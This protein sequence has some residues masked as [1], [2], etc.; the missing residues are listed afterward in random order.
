MPIKIIIITT[1]TIIIHTVNIVY[2][3]P[4]NNL[5]LMKGVSIVTAEKK[6]CHGLNVETDESFP[7]KSKN[8]IRRIRKGNLS[9]DLGIP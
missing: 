8:L 2:S 7:T 9:A 4:V 6:G 1:A 5:M 3:N